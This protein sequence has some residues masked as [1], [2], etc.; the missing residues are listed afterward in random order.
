LVDYKRERRLFGEQVRSVRSVGVN[1][2]PHVLKRGVDFKL[3]VPVWKALP[4]SK[5]YIRDWRI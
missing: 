4:V 5:T 1:E 3:C 2:M